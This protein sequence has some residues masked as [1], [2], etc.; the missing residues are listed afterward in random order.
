MVFYIIAKVLL[1]GYYGT[2]SSW[3]GVARVTKVAQVATMVLLGGI[4][5]GC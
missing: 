3:Y 4:P 5:V 1:G 2:L